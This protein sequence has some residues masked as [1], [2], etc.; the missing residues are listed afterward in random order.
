MFFG[1]N[2]KLETE[3]QSCQK[4]I[5]SL[6]QEIKQLTRKNSELEKE[7]EYADSNKIM[8][9][10]IKSLTNNLTNNL[11]DG[12]DRDLKIIQKRLRSKFRS[13]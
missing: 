11:T 5:F 1:S 8:N 2:T 6:K 3:L 12:C 13:T 7:V 10:L 4:E 9:D